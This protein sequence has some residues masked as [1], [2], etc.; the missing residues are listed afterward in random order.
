[1]STQRRNDH[2]CS[3]GQ[4][5]AKSLFCHSQKGTRGPF[6]ANAYL[7]GLALSR[8]PAVFRAV[9]AR[10]RR[11]YSRNASAGSFARIDKQPTTGSLGPTP[12]TSGG[13]PGQGQDS[14]PGLALATWR[15]TAAIFGA[16][17]DLG[18]RRA[19]HPDLSGRLRRQACIGIPVSG[20]TEVIDGPFG[21]PLERHTARLGQACSTLTP[22]VKAAAPRCSCLILPHTR[23]LAACPVPA[24]GWLASPVAVRGGAE[25]LG[26]H[27][28]LAQARG[29]SSSTASILTFGDASSNLARPLSGGRT[30]SIRHDGASTAASGR[31]PPPAWLLW[32][33]WAA[34]LYLR[35][36]G[37]G[38]GYMLP[39]AGR[40]HGSCPSAAAPG[41][42]HITS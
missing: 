34:R 2:R 3:G 9:A 38:L 11:L 4:R 41:Q 39:A 21:C 17:W 24:L 27:N 8:C 40:M 35:E 19:R 26:P 13:G 37:E 7:A 5:G 18:P 14:A 20:S 23:C 22:P 10:R 29:G 12:P 30:S 31:G 36:Y 16:L 28:S 25:S 1:M 42:C 6:R 33:V 15:P 32:A